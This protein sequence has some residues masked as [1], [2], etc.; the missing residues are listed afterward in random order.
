V[1]EEFIDRNLPL[2]RFGWP[3][4][5][6]DLAAF[7]ASERADLITGASIVVDGGQSNSLI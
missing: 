5:V 4:P 1:V 3:G 7:L 6:G 2:G